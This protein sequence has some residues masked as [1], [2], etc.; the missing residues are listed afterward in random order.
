MHCVGLR[1]FR[2]RHSKR[3]AAVTVCLAPGEA[4]TLAAAPRVAIGISLCGRRPQLS[5]L[6]IVLRL[7]ARAP[8][9][10][11]ASVQRDDSPLD[12][13]LCPPHPSL[14]DRRVVWQISRP[15][16]PATGYIR[17]ELTERLRLSSGAQ[18]PRMLVRNPDCQVLRLPAECLQVASWWTVGQARNLGAIVAA[19]SSGLFRPRPVP[20]EAAP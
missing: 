15:A 10:V 16:W 18:Q 12:Y 3:D 11:A 9:S 5:A 8:P 1:E 7:K 6:R 14:R 19:A 20:F 2:S 4:D 17:G 13:H